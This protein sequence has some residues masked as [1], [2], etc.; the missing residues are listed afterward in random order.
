MLEIAVTKSILLVS[1]WLFLPTFLAVP[2][3]NIGSLNHRILCQRRWIYRYLKSRRATPV[4]LK[5]ALC[6]F[7]NMWNFQ[8]I[9]PE[10]QICSEIIS[11]RTMVVLD[12]AHGLAAAT[13]TSGLLSKWRGSEDLKLGYWWAGMTFSMTLAR[14]T[15][16]LISA[17]CSELFFESLSFRKMDG[18]CLQ[19][20]TH[21]CAHYSS[22]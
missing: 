12:I 4:S 19:E 3:R 16:S 11:W 15:Y 2:K 22:S 8:F 1:F 9:W 14:Q 10:F 5:V 6:W 18:L 7:K 21:P 13:Q 20:F 17:L